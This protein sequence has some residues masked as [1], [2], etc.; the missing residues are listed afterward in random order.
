[1]S[2]LEYGISFIKQEGTNSV[3]EIFKVL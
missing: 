3:T 2:G 1:L